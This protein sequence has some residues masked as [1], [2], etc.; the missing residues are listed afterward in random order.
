ME[1]LGGSLLLQCFIFGGEREEAGHLHKD[2]QHPRSPVPLAREISCLSPT[3]AGL[4]FII[5][6]T[7][8]MPDL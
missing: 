2:I 8:G 1:E 7:H 6:N 3:V 5:L 4:C